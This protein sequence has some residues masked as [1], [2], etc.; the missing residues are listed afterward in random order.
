MI[1]GHCAFDE[2]HKCN[3]F[4]K[5]EPSLCDCARRHHRSV[6]DARRRTEIAELEAQWLMLDRT[7]WT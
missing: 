2:C 6:D 3:G 1:C 5:S 7:G 4:L